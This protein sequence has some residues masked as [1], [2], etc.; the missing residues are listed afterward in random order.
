MTEKKHVL[1]LLVDNQPGVLSRISGLFSGRG[2]NIES[3]CVAATMDPQV[4]RITITTKANQQI[5]EQIEK[6]LHKLINVI[7]VHEMTE[8]PS[9]QRELALIKVHASS[10]YRGEILRVVEIFKG[11]VLDVGQEHY[12]IEFTGNEEKMNA[13]LNL[14]KPIGIKEIARTGTIGMFRES[15]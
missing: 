5:I 9:V 1:S 4:S 7:K 11:K 8:T 15:K 13:I 2:F 10:K 3:L 12:V 6:Q 14:L